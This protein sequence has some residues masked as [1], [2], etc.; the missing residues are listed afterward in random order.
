MVARAQTATPM[1]HFT[2]VASSHPTQ[3]GLPLWKRKK[4]HLATEVLRFAWHN[5]INMQALN[6]KIA[7]FGG[8]HDDL[9]GMSFPTTSPS[10]LHASSSL[11]GQGHENS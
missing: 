5:A 10:D 1:G 6:Y 9:S 7:G 4:V 11:I 3:P 2:Q 8:S